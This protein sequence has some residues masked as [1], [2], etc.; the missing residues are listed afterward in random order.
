M[1]RRGR[2]G[3]RGP[4]ARLAG[5]MMTSPR[6]LE[7]N[8]RFQSSDYAAA[9]GLYEQLAL[10]ARRPRNAA[11]LLVEAG[12]ARL[13][14]GQVEQAMPLFR[15]GLGL[16]AERERWRA[17]H[18]LGAVVTRDLRDRGYA[19]QANEIAAWLGGQP[20]PE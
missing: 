4:L 10:S 2:M 1:F 20:A 6:L 5:R 17:V 8:R 19:Q 7:A 9:A 14:A 12:R 18:R 11:H 15:R 3:R 13:M 16:L